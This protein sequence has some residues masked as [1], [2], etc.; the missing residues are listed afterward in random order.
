MKADL[1]NEFLNN[2]N[3]HTGIIHR[4]CN[5]YFRDYT[6]RQDVFQEIVY[7]LWKSYAAFNNES[8]F[9]TWM[10]KVALN[11][12]IQ[13]IRKD[14]RTIQKDPINDLSLR[15]AVVEERAYS[16]DD[17]KMLYAAINTLTDVDKAIILLYLDEY[18]YDEIAIITGITKTN[19]SV[20]LVRIKKKLE[21]KLRNNQR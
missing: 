6:E 1:K 14:R 2:L 3:Q 16:N 7:Q 20:R 10:Y 9:S 19:V 12:A 13:H 15:I 4:V 5:S 21:D 8:K 18:S 11:T 17:M